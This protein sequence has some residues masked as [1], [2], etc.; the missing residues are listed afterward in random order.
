MK[1]VSQPEIREL[2]LTPPWRER[3]FP[4][5]EWVLLLVIVIEGGIFSIT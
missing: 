3:F 2:Q 5:N 1:S 4:N